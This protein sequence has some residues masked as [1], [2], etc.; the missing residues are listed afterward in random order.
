LVAISIPAQ[1]LLA[2]VG[3]FEQL[4]VRKRQVVVEL[5]YFN[6]PMTQGYAPKA[7]TE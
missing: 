4:G 2:L 7:P 6:L 3:V 5:A 1:S